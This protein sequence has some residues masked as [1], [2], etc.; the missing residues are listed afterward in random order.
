MPG[1]AWSAFPD[2][3]P[4]TQAASG[5]TWLRLRQRR[6][7]QGD[8]AT[9]GVLS[10]L[11]GPPTPAPSLNCEPC[12]LAGGP[13]GERPWRR[14]PV[15]CVSWLRG[16]I[17]RVALRAGPH[18]AGS[19]GFPGCPRRPEGN[20]LRLASLVWEGTGRSWLPGGTSLQGNNLGLFSSTSI[21]Q[22]SSDLPDGSRGKF[23]RGGALYTVGTVTPQAGLQDPYASPLPSPLL[24]TSQE[25]LQR[26]L[27]S[28]GAVVLNA[29]GKS[30]NFWKNLWK[31]HKLLEEEYVHA[32][33]KGFLSRAQKALK[34]KRDALN[35]ST[36]LT[37]RISLHQMTPLRL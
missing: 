1:R 25:R 6:V 32:E 26:S 31:N 11:L 23:P 10:P 29:K 27:R 5:A 30:I 13:R 37:F 8:A 2:L 15:G 4:G 14:G 18:W 16:R 20:N 17:A 35:D 7:A 21:F 3:H 24:T 34:D 33:G 28:R 9:C 22:G 12:G 19:Q 36:A